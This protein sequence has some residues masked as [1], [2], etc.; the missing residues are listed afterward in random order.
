[1]SK[2]DDRMEVRGQLGAMVIEYIE[3]CQLC[4]FDDGDYIAED[5]I[6]IVFDATDGE[7]VLKLEDINN[8]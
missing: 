5:I 7:I 6:D 4:G 3:I 1:M 2:Q 8:E